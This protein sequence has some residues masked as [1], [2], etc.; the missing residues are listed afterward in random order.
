MGTSKHA[1]IF[2]A[3]LLFSPNDLRYR[4][5]AQVVVGKFPVEEIKKLKQAATSGIPGSS[6]STPRGALNRS[7]GRP[8]SARNQSATSPFKTSSQPVLSNIP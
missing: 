2:Q 4:T 5:N 8:G 3:D 1:C 7:S 6:S